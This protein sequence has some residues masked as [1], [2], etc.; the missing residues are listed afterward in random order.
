MSKINASKTYKDKAKA[1]ADKKAAFGEDIDLNKYTSAGE[2]HPY[3]TDPS[4]LPPQ[5]KETDAERRR[6]A[7]RPQPAVGHLSPDGQYAHPQLRPSR[8]A[9]R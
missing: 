9:W 4:Q 6:H 7:G 2:E 5:T 8:K 1:A 3:Q